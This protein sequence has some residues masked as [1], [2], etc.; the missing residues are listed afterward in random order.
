MLLR[1]MNIISRILAIFLV[2]SRAH[3]TTTAAPTDDLSDLFDA[4]VMFARLS[5]DPAIN[6]RDAQLALNAYYMQATHGPCVSSAPSIAAPESRAKWFAWND[7]GDMKEEDAKR[8][9]ISY[10]TERIPNWRD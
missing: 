8:G 9:Y 2:V 10:L 7:L 1:V 6:N 3:A 5:L 4:A